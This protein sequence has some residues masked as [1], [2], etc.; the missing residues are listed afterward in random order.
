[1]SEC[2]FTGGIAY[3]SYLQPPHLFSY[4]P[5]F[6]KQTLWERGYHTSI[7]KSL[8]IFWEHFPLTPGFKEL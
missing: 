4:L 2:G 3:L 8:V 1:M 5:T 7:H 6:K